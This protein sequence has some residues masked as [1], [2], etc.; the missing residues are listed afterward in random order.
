MLC[1]IMLGYV[2]VY[3]VRELVLHLLS[4]ER[5]FLHLIIFIDFQRT[6]LP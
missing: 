1:Y 5:V 3:Y 4:G 2:M 6:F